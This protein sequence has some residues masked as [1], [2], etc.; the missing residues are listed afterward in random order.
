MQTAHED[1]QG[2]SREYSRIVRATAA[3][4]YS[5]VTG[6]LCSKIWT[7]ERQEEQAFFTDEHYHQAWQ[8]RQEQRK[9]GIVTDASDQSN[10]CYRWL[11]NANGKTNV[12]F[13]L[14]WHQA[15]TSQIYYKQRKIYPTHTPASKSGLEAKER[16]KHSSPPSKDNS[17]QASMG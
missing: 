4:P 8:E 16:I 13:R 2:P 5:V 7:K 9:L 6:E 1:G 14:C 15:S 11:G 3:T 17:H 12:A 10:I